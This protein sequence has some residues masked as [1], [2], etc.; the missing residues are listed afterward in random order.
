MDNM[1]A[2]V[3]LAGM[4]L[5]GLLCI[6]VIYAEFTWTERKRKRNDDS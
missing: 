2:S 1:I 5:G 3:L 6:L 4:A